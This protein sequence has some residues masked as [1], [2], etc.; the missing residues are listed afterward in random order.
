VSKIAT[1]AEELELFD[2]VM[3]QY[4][5]LIDLA[6]KPTN[7]PEELRT[8]DR[9]VSGCISQIWIDVGAVDDRTKIYYDSD[10]MI[11][12]GVTHL[13]CDCFDNLPIEDAKQINKDE[14]EVLGIAE[15]LSSNR[16]SGLAS[17]INTLQSKVAAL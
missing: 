10:A 12:K 11:T 17:L 8:D 14:F 5:F 1:W 13:I 16:R 9:L 2:D 3:D 7:L 15:I 6:K 4:T